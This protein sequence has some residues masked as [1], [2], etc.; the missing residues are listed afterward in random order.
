ML[1][2]RIVIVSIFLIIL[3]ACG[4]GMPEDMQAFVEAQYPSATIAGTSS[5]GIGPSRQNDNVT[6]AWCVD[7]AD[8]PSPIVV[9]RDLDTGLHI[10]EAWGYGFESCAE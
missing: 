1:S 5:M 10:V 8:A 4:N 7:F 2:I 9:Y 6:N 3:V